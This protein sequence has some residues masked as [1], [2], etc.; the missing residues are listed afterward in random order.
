MNLNTLKKTCRGCAASRHNICELGY[1]AIFSSDEP[2]FIRAVG[3]PQE[4]C[5]KPKNN[6]DLIYAKKFY[7]KMK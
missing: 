3:T 5:P 7:M 1:S 6:R 2:T 4:K